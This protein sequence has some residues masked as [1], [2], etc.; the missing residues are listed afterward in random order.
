MAAGKIPT[1]DAI[2]FLPE[3]KDFDCE[4]RECDSMPDKDSNLNSEQ[5]STEING[6]EKTTTGSTAS[7]LRRLDDD[8]TLEKTPKSRWRRTEPETYLRNKTYDEICEKSIPVNHQKLFMKLVSWA[9]QS[10]MLRLAEQLSFWV[11]KV[12]E[13]TTEKNKNDKNHLGR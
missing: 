4:K 12:R 5:E 9:L 10:M 8:V 2:T 3:N 6:D 1:C 13:E 11:Y 7:K